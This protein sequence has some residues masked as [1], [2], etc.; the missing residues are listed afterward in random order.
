MSLRCDKS[1]AQFQLLKLW[2]DEYVALITLRFEHTY[3]VPADLLLQ[4]FDNLTVGVGS[5]GLYGE[6]DQD[7]PTA[8]PPMR[9]T[10]S[11]QPQQSSSSTPPVDSALMSQAESDFWTSLSSDAPTGDSNPNLSQQQSQSMLNAWVMPKSEPIFD[12]AQ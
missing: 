11:Q 12:E 7:L 5:G 8:V 3:S 9:A 10:T 6:V 2:M 1:I 4:P